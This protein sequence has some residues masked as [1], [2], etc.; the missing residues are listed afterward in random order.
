MTLTAIILTFNEQKHIQACIQSLSFAD[1]V[2]V[3]DSFSTDATVQLATEQG[4]HVV[5]NHFVNYA[6]QRNDA[7][8]H[9]AGQTDWVLFVDADERVSPDLAQEIHAVIQRD[10]AKQAIEFRVG[11]VSSGIR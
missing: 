6:Q 2:V 1:R 10:G 8:Q 11:I 9:V 4:A 3:F 7:L 5:Q